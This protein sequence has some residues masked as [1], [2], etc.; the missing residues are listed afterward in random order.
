MGIISKISDL[1][2]RAPKVG[3][4]RLHGPIGTGG[5]GRSLEYARIDPIIERAFKIPGLA[6]IALSINSPGGAPVQSAL[7]GGR[8]RELADRKKVPVYAFCEDVAASGGYWIACAADEIF[9]DPNTVIGSI[10]VVSAGFGF[11][12]A[13][14]RLGVE[15]RVRTAGENKWRLDPFQPAKQED[16]EW[17]KELQLKLHGSFID[18]VK[19]R[20]GEKLAENPALFTG[21][22]YL[23]SDAVRLGLADSF[24]TMRAVL[25][26]RFGDNVKLLSVAPKRSFL[27][28]LTGASNQPTSVEAIAAQA[29]G[30]VLDEAERRALMA[31]YGL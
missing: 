3:L 16:E 18:Y 8:I 2:S 10:G 7:I 5:F 4:I 21:E 28:R 15:R 1:F 30:G 24:G 26:Y 13:I 20:R 19:S 29:V 22:A 27:S 12:K 6:A 23:G 11:D 9:V 17:L 14:D 25:E 31:R